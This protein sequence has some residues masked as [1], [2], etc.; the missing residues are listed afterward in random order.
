MLPFQGRQQFAPP[1]SRPQLPSWGTAACGGLAMG[2][3]RER[4]L[5]TSWQ[6]PAGKLGPTSCAFGR[7][8]VAD[9]DA[10]GTTAG[11]YIT[12]MQ[13]TEYQHC[14]DLGL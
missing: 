10:V 11:Y 6:A 2:E 8:G 9:F 1:A 13:P 5:P 14:F 4:V 3:R 12:N 7:W